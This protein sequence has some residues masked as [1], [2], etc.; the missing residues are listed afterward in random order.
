MHRLATIVNV[1]ASARF[2]VKTVA[3]DSIAWNMGLQGSDGIVTI[4]EREIPVGGNTW[5]TIRLIFFSNGYRA[6][7]LPLQ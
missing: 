1:P 3:Q 2:L 5:P 4:G 7:A 6:L